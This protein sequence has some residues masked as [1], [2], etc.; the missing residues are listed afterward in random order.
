ML[1]EVAKK[2]EI[3]PGGMK[4]VELNEKEIV[5]CNYDGEI[6]AVSRRCGHENAPLEMGIL[7][8][9]ILTCPMH[10]VQ[11]DITNGEALNDPVYHYF[12]DEPTEEDNFSRWMGRLMSHVKTCDIETY[13]VRVDGDSIKV[14]I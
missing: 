8:G 2:S 5:L 7:E 10:H 3:A 6:Y 11:F 13:K 1:I 12:G 4:A 9:Y 14:E